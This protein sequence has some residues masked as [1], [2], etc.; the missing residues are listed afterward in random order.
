MPVSNTQPST[1]IEKIPL[2]TRIKLWN[3]RRLHHARIKRLLRDDPKDRMAIPR[4]E[5]VRSLLFIEA[6]EG[7]GDFLYYLGLLKALSENGVTVDVVSLPETYKRYESV[8]FLRN[9]FSMDN[10]AHLS[11]IAAIQYDLAFDVTYV[12]ALH[13]DLRVPILRVLKCHTMTIGDVAAHS[14]LFDEFVDVGVRCH[15]KDRNAIML[16]A[17]LGH[18]AVS[19]PLPPFYQH[20]EQTP[21]ADEFIASWN[22]RNHVYVNGVARVAERSL[23]REQIL[24]LVDLFNERKE[25]V[26]I[27]YTDF[28]IEESECVKRLPTMPFSDFTEVVRHCKAAITP[29][30]SVVHL[31]SI[32]HLPIFGIYCGNNRDYWPQYAMQD[33][34]A[35][36]SEGSV[37]FFEDD[38]GT[39]WQSD[40]V[41]KHK[42]KA[43][44]T[45]SPDAI[46]QAVCEFLVHQGLF[47]TNEQEQ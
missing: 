18:S 37:S 41:Y 16:N 36:L 23:S 43:V 28:P 5:T 17:I 44:S 25:A 33:V 26:G 24:A 15:W 30:T 1:A 11:R 21:L 6:Q 9:V 7:W 34:W 27:F 8:S 4:P 29:D 12:N 38:P 40:F 35:P 31:G 20:S 19:V 32:F 46:T 42:K 22:G 45:Y 39:T 14:K 10:Q 3:R 13:W 2:L 47:H